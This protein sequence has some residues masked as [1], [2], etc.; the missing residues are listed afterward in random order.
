[1]KS[2]AA[3]SARNALSRSP[4]SPVHSSER[5]LPMISAGFQPNVRSQAGEAKRRTPSAVTR[6]E[7]VRFVQSCGRCRPL[8]IESALERINE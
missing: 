7:T 6:R 2:P 5:C 3:A 4:P 8:S 1:M